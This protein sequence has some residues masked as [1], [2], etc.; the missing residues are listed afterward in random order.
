MAASLQQLLSKQPPTTS[1]AHEAFAQHSEAIF[2]DFKGILPL[3][4]GKRRSGPFIHLKLPRSIIQDS[5]A[6]LQ[7]I[8]DMVWV[9]DLRLFSFVTTIR[10]QDASSGQSRLRALQI[11]ADSAHLYQQLVWHLD[12]DAEDDIV[13]FRRSSA[14][15]DL[16]PKEIWSQLFAAKPT[17][18][19][20]IFSFERLAERFGGEDEIPEP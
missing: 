17:P 13:A 2:S 12:F 9:Y 8:S 3:F 20:R 16:I 10:M 14:E 19:S 1:G 6:L 7:S 18:E 5:E 15:P 4:L 11:T